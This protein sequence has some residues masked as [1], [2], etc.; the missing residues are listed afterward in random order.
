MFM[1]VECVNCLSLLLLLGSYTICSSVVTLFADPQ[2]SIE[3][4]VSVT[5]GNNQALVLSANFAS[6]DSITI[7]FMVVNGGTSKLQ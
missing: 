2:I 7:P 6:Q 1:G 3:E 4:T 5:E